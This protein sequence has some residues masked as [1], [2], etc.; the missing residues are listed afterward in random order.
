MHQRRLGD[1]LL[2]DLTASEKR[3]Q[4]L[5]TT[6]VSLTPVDDAQVPIHKVGRRINLLDRHE[7]RR[8]DPSPNKSNVNEERETKAEPYVLNKG[9][10][11]LKQ[12][13]NSIF[14]YYDHLA[15]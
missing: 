9:N 7:Q 2:Q 8:R 6:T 11:G 5:Q 1:P 10:F 14:F 15:K 13:L 12:K 3:E 4:C